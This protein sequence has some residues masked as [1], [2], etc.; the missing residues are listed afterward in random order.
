MYLSKVFS[1]VVISLVVLTSSI[2]SYVLLRQSNPFSKEDPAPLVAVPRPVVITPPSLEKIERSITFSSPHAISWEEPPFRYAVTGVSVGTFTVSKGS[3]ITVSGT[4]KKYVPGEKVPALEITIKVTNRGSSPTCPAMNLRN[5]INEEG[6]LGTP[7][8]RQFLFSSGSCVLNALSSETQQI[9]FAL[10]SI[11]SLESIP[12]QFT[13]Y[14]DGTSQIF[15]SII[16]E[17][18]KGLRVEKVKAPKGFL[19]G[20]PVPTPFMQASF[21]LLA[22]TERMKINRGDMINIAWKLTGGKPTSIISYILRGTPLDG[23]FTKRQ[24]GS[25]TTAQ[26]EKGSFQVKVLPGTYVL[27]VQSPGAG[28]A[29]SVDIEVLGGPQKFSAK[30]SSLEIDE[31]DSSNQTRGQIINDGICAV[32][33]NALVK[34][35]FGEPISGKVVDIRSDRAGIEKIYHTTESTDE[36]GMQTF[37]L[38]SQS[39][40]VASITAT[41]EGIP[42]ANSVILQVLDKATYKCLQDTGYGE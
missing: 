32:N 26:Q 40:G 13:I 4:E 1:I 9:I 31:Y 15:F 16:T 25:F 14:T 3:M 20:S 22:P 21:E 36:Y 6:D 38:T 41:V 39:I 30:K 34:D 28:L 24:S 12:K 7:L 5:V 29:R 35:E 2:S 18:A 17:G 37:A 23:G 10:E 8:N 42:F 33:V 19:L 27:T 11:P